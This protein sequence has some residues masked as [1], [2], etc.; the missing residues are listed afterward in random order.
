MSVFNAGMVQV[1]KDDPNSIEVRAIHDGHLVGK[2]ILI[3]IDGEIKYIEG[4]QI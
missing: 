2:K 1:S 4:V 3:A